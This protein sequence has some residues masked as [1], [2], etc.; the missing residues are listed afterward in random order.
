MRETAV[1]LMTTAE[2]AVYLRLKERTVYEMVARR[3]IPCSRATGKLLF[4]RPLIDAWIEG[5]TE[6][7]HGEPSSPPP[8]YAGSSE[9]L[10]EWAL[11]QS[12]SGIAVLVGGSRL[13][14]EA[15]ARGEAVLA[16]VHIL[17]AAS[18]SY[19][20]AA[21][22]ALVP[23]PD[24]VAV[25]WARRSQGLMVAPGNPHRIA[26]L[27]D[28]VRRGLRIACRREGSGSRLLLDTLLAG[29]DLTVG[30]VARERIADSQ[31]DLASMIALGDADCGVGIAAAAAGL[32]FLPLV[33][34]EFDLVMRRR[35]Y[36]EAPVQALFAFARSE[37]LVRRA[38]HLGGYD[39]GELGTVRHNA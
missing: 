37:A 30:T 7:P 36:F 15:I 12:G 2:V 38:A 11:R 31:G 23:R 21:I 9:P 28:A 32:D 29:E 17:D 20:R 13:G 10:L 27:G 22:C 35:D 19:N 1:P 26:S 16:G 5:H 24:V 18:G 25:H 8:I 4:S 14:L 34:E 3:Q 6:M 39:L 33:W